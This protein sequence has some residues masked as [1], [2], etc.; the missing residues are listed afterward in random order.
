MAQ[1]TE[2]ERAL[3]GKVRAEFVKRGISEEKSGK[4]WGDCEQ[5]HYRNGMAAGYAE[6]FCWLDKVICGSVS[7]E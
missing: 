5:G 7:L 3:L 2:S 1:L 6:A 4:E